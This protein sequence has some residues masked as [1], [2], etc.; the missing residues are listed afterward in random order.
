[1]GT[2]SFGRR[3]EL[4]ETL[5]EPNGSLSAILTVIDQTGDAR[6]RDEFR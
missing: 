1:M 3:A 5:G 4:R 6:N 2:Y